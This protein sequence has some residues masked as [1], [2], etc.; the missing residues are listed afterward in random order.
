MG[1]HTTDEVY[2]RLEEVKKELDKN[3]QQEVT[4]AHFNSKIVELKAAIE[5]GG[6]G[7]EK[8]KEK[9]KSEWDII[10]EKLLI[11]DAIKLFK[12]FTDIANGTNIVAQVVAF[13]TVVGGAVALFGKFRTLIT[14]SIDKVKAVLA[15]IKNL[16][17]KI[18]G[19][20]RGERQ[21]FGRDREGNWGLQPERSSQDRRNAVREG[22]R[23]FRQRRS[24]RGSGASGLPG[25]GDAR[26]LG[27]A[28]SRVN[29]QITALDG[30]KSKLPS[31]AKM[32]RTASA[33]NKLSEVLE[34]VT[35]RLRPAELD[36]LTEATDRLNHKMSAFDHEKLPKPRTLRDIAKAAKEVHDNADNVRQMFQRLATAST[37][38]AN[39]IA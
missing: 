22:S 16:T 21:Y 36:N 17:L 31:A 24:G 3:T 38:A 26:D 19:R 5:K 37:D 32:K 14:G 28:L 8:K 23:R 9:D 11:D 39:S 35:E 10:K 30:L 29:S 12:Q 1:K 18:T 15:S 13:G 33:A 4:T 34:K 2:D 27:Q 6:K 7:Q 25:A 20:F